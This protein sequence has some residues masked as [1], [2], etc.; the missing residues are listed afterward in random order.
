MALDLPV[1]SK[2]FADNPQGAHQALVLFMSA[3]GKANVLWPQAFKS[4][5]IS[6]Q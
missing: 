1:V 6:Y 4:T 2:A 3:N 5:R